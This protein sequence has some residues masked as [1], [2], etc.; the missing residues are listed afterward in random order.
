MHHTVDENKMK[1][2]LIPFNKNC[3][4]NLS[5]VFDND[6][7]SKG[8]YRQKV[9]GINN[10]SILIK[11]NIT[12]NMIYMIQSPGINSSWTFIDNL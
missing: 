1:L 4:P 12:V 6:T 9:A 2:K 10:N 3:Q 8:L 11:I 5:R 7:D